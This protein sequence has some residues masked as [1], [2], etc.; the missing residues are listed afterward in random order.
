VK[1]IG[2][3]GGSFDPVH[4]GHMALAQT[5]IE[6]LRLDELHLM[7]TGFS[8]QKQRQLS[9]SEDRIAMLNLAVKTLQPKFQSRISID[10]RETLK[11]GPSYSY[12]SL[13]DIREQLGNGCSITMV[14]GSDQLRN[15]NTWYRW[16][17]LLSVCNLAVTQRESISLQNL[18]EPIEP[19]V[20]AHG[21]QSL[22]GQTCGKIAFF[23]M[24]PVAVSSTVLRRAIATGQPVNHLVPEPVLRYIAQ[25]QLYKVTP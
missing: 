19:Y 20:Q 18:P 16:Q 2:V 11:E 1:H 21:S 13:L 7:P 9:S 3:F 22:V 6:A 25:K 24:P 14:L 8:W 5:A 15:L 23:S 17:D 4:V 10:P 12:D